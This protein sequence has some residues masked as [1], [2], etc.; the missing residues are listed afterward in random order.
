MLS[1]KFALSI[2]AGLLAA[3]AAQAEVIYSEDFSTSGSASGSAYTQVGQGANTSPG[4]YGIVSNPA[5]AFTNP[6]QSFFDHTT[7]T[8]DGRML[9]F[10]GAY[11]QTSLWSQV[12]DLESGVTYTFSF[13]ARAGS[14]NYPTIGLYV[15][16]VSTGELLYTVLD[17]WTQFLYTFTPIASGQSTF[18]LASLPFTGSG[19]D[20]AIDDIVL[21]RPDQQTPANPVS[22]PGS[23][24]LLGI[25]A[26]SMGLAS[27][28]KKGD[29]A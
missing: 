22:A 14:W 8:S 11:T 23:A 16:G 5:D 6:Y 15:D 2:A 18:M 21:S 7:G 13:W 1:K 28:R 4:T 25:G 3:T 27:R 20:G 19:N 9:F 29:S 26:I 10:D 24:L 17:D 12:F